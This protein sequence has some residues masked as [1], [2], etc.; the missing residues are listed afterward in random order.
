MRSKSFLALLG[1]V[2]LLW[3]TRASCDEEA[4]EHFEQA[5]TLLAAGETREAIDLLKSAL[6]VNPDSGS[7]IRL[8]ASAYLGQ[9]NEFWALKTLNGHAVRTGD[10]ETLTWIAWIHLNNGKLEETQEAFNA[11]EGEM[12]DP[13]ACRMHLLRAML[14]KVGQQNLEALEELEK[15][16][17][18]E[19]MFVEDCAVMS[20]LEGTIDPGR[21]PPLS[22]K[23]ALGLGWKSNVPQSSIVEESKEEASALIELENE[24]RLV[25]PTYRAFRPVLEYRLLLRYYPANDVWK[26]SFGEIG[27]RAGI[28]LGYTH[29]RVGLYY[30]N[31]NLLLA[32]Y[33]D[34]DDYPQLYYET[35]RGEFELEATDWLFVFGGAGRKIF[36]EQDRTRTEAD[37][38][39][40]VMKSLSD[41]ISLTGVLAGRIHDAQIKAYDL[42][43]TS[44][45]IFFRIPVS[46]DGF[47]RLSGTASFDDYHSSDSSSCRDFEYKR[48]RDLML[49]WKG[50][51]WSPAWKGLRVGLSY[52]YTNRDS[53]INSFSFE[54]H[55]VL[56][57]IFWRGDFDPWR[58]EHTRSDLHVGLDYGL[59][60]TLAP[61]ER[62]QDLIRQEDM[63]RRCNSCVE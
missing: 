15:A 46:K 7:L 25:V 34:C 31:T 1:C 47:T 4:V 28:I 62:I 45:M 5:R 36:R 29:P 38:G 60:R 50:A 37:I 49:R 33:K 52:Q 10:H 8:L 55:E 11:A 16:R 59:Q 19:S 53:S 43:G 48:R 6:A 18:R 2:M 23:A 30:A 61:E 44:A 14:L 58:P 63:V 51:Y 40:A 3:S 41:R 32:R 54:D 22:F 17:R 9:G 13:E 20:H 39:M 35:H 27:G 57:R 12:S 21:I 24:G 42:R 56:L 26:L